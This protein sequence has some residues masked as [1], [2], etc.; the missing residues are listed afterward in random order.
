MDPNDSATSLSIK[1]S[2]A[3]VLENDQKIIYAQCGSFHLGALTNTGRAYTG[4]D[5]ASYKLCRGEQ[6]TKDLGLALVP[7]DHFFTSMHIAG[8]Y[9]LLGTRSG[10]VLV[11]GYFARVEYQTLTE[12][13]SFNCPVRHLSGDFNATLIAVSEFNKITEIE[14]DRD[15]KKE[16]RVDFSPQTRYN[17]CTAALCRYNMFICLMDKHVNISLHFTKLINAQRNNLFTDITIIN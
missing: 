13:T 5:T 6:D 7:S 10:S 2:I 17:V 12:V 16:T 3:N 1:Y 8:D 4:G 14:F 15:G 11:C 9:T